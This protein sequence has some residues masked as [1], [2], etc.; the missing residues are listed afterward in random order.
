MTARIVE[1]ADC[2]QARRHYARGVCHPCYGRAYRAKVLAGYQPSRQTSQIDRFDWV[3]VERLMAGRRAEVHPSE[4][5][6]TARELIRRGVPRYDA[7]LLCGMSGK[8]LKE[9]AA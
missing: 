3:V 8:T 9:V 5:D 1:C 6:A 2:G 4:R 7:G